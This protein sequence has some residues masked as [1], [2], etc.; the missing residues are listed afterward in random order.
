MESQLVLSD[1]EVSSQALQKMLPGLRFGGN[2]A[3][4][5]TKRA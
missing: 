5:E 4:C 1:V 2:V 3:N